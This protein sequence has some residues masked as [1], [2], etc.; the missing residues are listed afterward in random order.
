VCQATTKNPLCGD[1][2]NFG[3]K[4]GYAPFHNVTVAKY[5]GNET[6]WAEAAISRLASFGFNGISGW[7]ASVAEVSA[8]SHVRGAE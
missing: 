1:S 3:G 7:S 5:A 6:A 8:A 4:L 2:L